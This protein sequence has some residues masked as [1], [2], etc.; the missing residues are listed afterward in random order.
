MHIF[1]DGNNK[2]VLLLHIPKCAGTSCGQFLHKHAQRHKWYNLNDGYYNDHIPIKVAK[3][4]VDY[5]YAIA[6]VRNPY[7][8][9]LSKYFY[10]TKTNHHPGY[11]NY[12]IQN[13]L[14]K[15]LN[16]KDSGCWTPEGWRKQIEYIDETVH[17]YKI[18]EQDPIDILNK[19]IGTNHTHEK[20][21]KTD[22]NYSLTKNEMCDIFHIYKEDF[23]RLNYESLY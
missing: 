8:R 13:F 6:F 4:I 19:L 16:L 12:S 10:L 15:R 23:E 9:F 1:A 22:Y 11:E 3:Q 2:T 7:E 17:I 5:D 14:D 20:A 18:E 21:N